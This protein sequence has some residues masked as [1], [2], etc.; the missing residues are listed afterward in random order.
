MR[1]RTITM[2]LLNSSNDGFDGPPLMMARL[3]PERDFIQSQSSAALSLVMMNTVMDNGYK[4][5]KT[6][7][8]TFCIHLFKS[9][10]SKTGYSDSLGSYPLPR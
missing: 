10:R 1:G 8:D 3:R 9:L 2:L 7:E 5:P 6:E 4:A